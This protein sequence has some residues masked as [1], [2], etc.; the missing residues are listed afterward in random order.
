[1][2]EGDPPRTGRLQTLTPLRQ[3]LPACLMRARESLMARI[4]PTLRAYD[5]TEPQW[6]VLRTL[7]SLD[8]IEI[9]Q[10]A[11]LVFLLPSSL[12]RILRDL[13][14]RGLV[15]RRTSEADLRKGLVSISDKGVALIEAAQPSTMAV[16][17]EIERLYGSERLG[18]LLALLG[19]LEDAL[20]APQPSE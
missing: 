7:A 8:Q 19:E 17:A 15:E 6:R 13:G 3:S 5:V 18:R 9:T 16:A 10:L 4:R 14:A 20:G 12:S 11:E 1:M 2:D